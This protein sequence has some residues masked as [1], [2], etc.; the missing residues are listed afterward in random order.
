MTR[1][2][3]SLA[4]ALVVGCGESSRPTG[5]PATTTDLTSTDTQLLHRYIN[6]AREPR[7]VQWKTS[8]L[9]RNPD[10]ALTALFRYA[11]ADL[12][13]IEAGSQKL[14]SPPA[15]PIDILN[16]WFPAQMR[17]RYA[18]GPRDPRGVITPDANLRTADPFIAADRSPLVQGR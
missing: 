16:A 3:F 12:D 9:P 5:A 18:N 10:W 6:L 15:I 4:F 17:E 7:S 1:C 8:K 14:P 13:A 2:L 11:R